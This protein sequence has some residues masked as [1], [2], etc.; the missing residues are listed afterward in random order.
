MQ[1]KKIRDW[2]IE[3][4]LGEGGMGQ[5]WR[6][7]HTLLNRIFAIKIIARELLADPRF[8][9]LFMREAGMQAELQHP[10]IIPATDFFIDDGLHFLVMPYVEGQS[11][12][13]RM[14]TNKNPQTGK[15]AP[16]PPQEAMAIAFQVMH[17]LDYAHQHRVIHRDVKPSNILLDKRGDAYLTDFGVALKMDKPRTTSAGKVVG[18]SAYM[19]PEQIQR[20]REMDHRTDVYSFGCV[21]Y[22]MLAGGPVF[23][24]NDVE[25][26]TDFFIKESH[27]KRTPE[28]LRKRNPNVPVAVEAIVSK[29]LAK[30]PNDRF[31]GCGEF[32]RELAKA[33]EG[34]ESL[35]RCSACGEK[36]KFANPESLVAESK[37][38]KCGRAL[39]P[40]F[41]PKPPARVVGWVVTVALLAI[42]SL[43]M[44]IGW[45]AAADAEKKTKSDLTSTESRLSDAEAAKASTERQLQSVTQERDTLK[46]RLTTFTSAPAGI[47]ILNSTN[48]TIRYVYMAK[49]S[50]FPGSDRLGSSTIAPTRSQRFTLAP[51]MYK[52][53]TKDAQEI[54]C[55]WDQEVDVVGGSELTIE[56]KVNSSLPGPCMLN[57]TVR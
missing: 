9:S 2:E 41:V 44:M 11:L 51:G 26:D 13:E 30:N 25:G 27:V 6:A 46:G 37:C 57:R 48:D 5:V 43:V 7:R 20:P 49:S 47:T 3:S 15:R 38:S 12:E 22:E 21:L 40:A 52:F 1:G 28:P 34:T 42:F 36:C 14:E 19:S 23:E 24:I 31:S 56:L 8:E 33:I 45:A 53:R 4:L 39:F 50:E 10:H 18:T 35:I 55:D 17:A 29:A 16:L 32:A 54:V